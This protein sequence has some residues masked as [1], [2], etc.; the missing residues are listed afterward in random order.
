MLGTRAACA[1][2]GTLGDFRSA[3]SGAALFAALVSPTSN[4]AKLAAEIIEYEVDVA[5]NGANPAPT[6]ATEA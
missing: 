5:I 2:S 4:H 3:P 6:F 1:A